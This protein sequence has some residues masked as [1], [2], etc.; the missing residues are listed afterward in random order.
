MQMR[1]GVKRHTVGCTDDLSHH[2]DS[3]HGASGSSQNPS[4]SRTR[5]T[6]LLTV[7]ERPPGKWAQIIYQT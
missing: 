5:R 4:N 6:G 3:G 1:G 2:G 7:M